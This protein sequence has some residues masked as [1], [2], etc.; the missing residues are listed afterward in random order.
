M[1]WRC[2]RKPVDVEFGFVCLSQEGSGH[3]VLV[4]LLTA[5]SIW[6]TGSS[7]CLPTLLYH[8]EFLIEW[9][10]NC[11]YLISKEIYPC[12]RRLVD[13]FIFPQLD[14]RLYSSKFMEVQ[15]HYCVQKSLTQHHGLIQCHLFHTPQTNIFQISFNTMFVTM[16]WF[17]HLGFQTMKFHARH[18]SRSSRHHRFTHFNII[19]RLHMMNFLLFNFI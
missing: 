3:S 4:C 5:T 12:N 10:I 9:L 18:N 15:V 6:V 16:S 8:L 11:K 17:I 19:W 1:L 7:V 2:L 14:N 13:K